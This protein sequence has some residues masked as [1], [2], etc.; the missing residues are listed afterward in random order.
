MQLNID[1]DNLASLYSYEVYTL[2]F[3]CI[4]WSFLVD[5]LL[6]QETQH[7]LDTFPRHIKML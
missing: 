3:A 4:F 2:G 6:E 5:V 7:E 1:L